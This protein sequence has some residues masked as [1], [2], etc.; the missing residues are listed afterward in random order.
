[1]ALYKAF[2]VSAGDTLGRQL[3][4]I[5]AASNGEAVEAAE[6]R[7][8]ERL[9]AGQSIECRFIPD[10]MFRAESTSTFYGSDY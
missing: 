9:K 4:L 6:E 3:G 7:Y 10:D 5:E 1:M 8:A 2:A